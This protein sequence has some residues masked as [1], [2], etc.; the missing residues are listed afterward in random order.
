[1]KILAKVNSVGNTLVAEACY[2]INLEDGDYELEI[3]KLS[4]KRSLEQN[5]YFWALVGE[6]AKREDGDLREVDKLYDNL[7]KIAGTKY[8]VAYMKKE[9]IESFK[10]FDVIKHYYIKEE[11]VVN[12]TLY[13]TVYIFYGSSKFDTKQMSDLIDTTLKYAELVGVPNINN[14]WKGVLN[15]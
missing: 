4:K 1:M 13:A 14:Y 8:E 7:L 6:I 5:K 15:A 11:K 10:K 2:P 9:A 12:N 3:K